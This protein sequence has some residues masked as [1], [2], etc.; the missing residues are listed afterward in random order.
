MGVVVGRRP[1]TADGGAVARDQPR[2]AVRGREAGRRARGAV[3]GLGD[4]GVGEAHRDGG[5]RDA[6]ARAGACRDEGVVACHRAVAA[7]DARDAQPRRRERGGAHHVR[8]VV[9]HAAVG[10]RGGRV[11]R[12]QAG[13]GVR[14]RESRGCAG[15]AVVGLGDAG[16]AQA[17]GQRRRVDRERAVGIRDQ[18]SELARVQ[19]AGRD[20]VA[21]RVL[22]AL[23]R[24]A[25]GER[26]RQRGRDAHAIRGVGDAVAAAVGSAAVRRRLVVGGRRHGRHERPQQ[27]GGV[28]VV[29][30]P[31]A[32]EVEADERGRLLDVRGRDVA[33]AVGDCAAV[34]ARPHQRAGGIGVGDVAGLAG[35]AAVHARQAA[36]VAAAADGA[37]GVDVVHRAAVVPADQ[38]ADMAA[39]GDATRGV[40]VADGAVVVAAHEAA[41]AVVSAHVAGGEA[42]A[43]GARAGGSGRSAEQSA[44]PVARAGDRARGVAVDDLAAAGAGVA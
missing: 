30:C 37:R 43:D 25:V 12:H 34:L 39:A 9:G 35:A 15:G 21:A 36:A 32:A 5:R 33:G 42:V 2:D 40:A 44:S 1:R 14:G 29:D 28:A 16:V 22:G 38:A 7:G 17:H 3:V 26:A 6:G 23:R 20:H 8:A 11:A 19:P 4:A 41:D 10:D 27:R 18:V 24:A 31:G 13:V